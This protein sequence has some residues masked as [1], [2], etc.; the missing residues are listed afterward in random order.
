MKKL[1]GIVVL[2]LSFL[3]SAYSEMSYELDKDEFSGKTYHYIMSN[4]SKPNKPL[5]FP[6]QDTE[7]SLIVVCLEGSHHHA[8]VY[9]TEVNLTGGKINDGYE[10]HTLKIK[11][12][13]KI[14]NIWATQDFGKKTLYFN[15]T[16]SDKKKII[17]LMK[18]ND[19]IMIQF[20][21]YQ[22]GRRFYKYDTKG[23]SK[24]FDQHC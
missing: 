19:E 9:F 8:Y 4:F 1:L 18:I 7:S 5:D 3:E 17:E 16:K 15:M 2:T 22:D 14:E 12:G 21:H 10:L 6:Y 13:E 24:L 11:T 20:N 23:F